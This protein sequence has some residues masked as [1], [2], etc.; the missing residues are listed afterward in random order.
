MRF[1][2]TVILV[3][4]ISI[5]ISCDL[6][7][8]SNSNDFEIK[9]YVNG[10]FPHL[11]MVADH[12]PRT[13]AGVGALMPW[14]DRLW[15]ITYVAHK[16]STGSGTGL[17]SIDE[18][19]NLEKHPKSIV[20]TYANR[21]IHGPSDQLFIGPYTINTKGQV[22]I[23]D[24]LVNHR[25][26]ATMEHLTEPDNKVYVLAMEGEFFEVDVHT[27]EVEKLFDLNIELNMSGGTRPHFKDGFTNHGRVVIANN[28]FDSIN[29]TDGRL[30]EW[31]GNTWKVLKETAFT[32]VWSARAS[33][34]P[35]IATG[36]DKASVILM[37]LIDDEWQTY[38]LPKASRAYDQTSY[39]EWMR[40]REVE[41]ERVLM[42]VHGM[43]YEIG[44]HTWK[45]SL[46]A[47]RPISTHLRI[48]PDFT[49]WRGMLVLGGNQATPMQFGQSNLDR[50][51]LAGQ[52][53][54]GL[55]FGVT[56]DLWSFGKPTGSGG[57]WYDS[58]IEANEY[59]DPFLMGGFDKKSVH[60]YHSSE[61]TVLFTFE[62]D[63]I[64]DGNWHKYKTI[65]VPSD[66][67]VYY[68]FHNSYSAQWIRV[69]ADKN[70]EA[71]VYFIYQ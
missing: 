42:D 23:I 61:S 7:G 63:F 52:P 36:W 22:R 21:I 15:A 62:V 57:V 10:V 71:T 51:P 32:E 66:K 1:L 28:T 43:F 58:E 41:T 18:N 11:G 12:S 55:W 65:E 50:N 29:D 53:Q 19:F 60:L 14:A 17:Y 16:K 38:R 44:Y 64:G 59:S 4:S 70:C 25:L 35:M 39:V 33:G 46:W 5:T 54:A 67:Y 13:E 26:A 34:S 69:K 9:H 68:E 6:I 3:I 27:L 24:G 56:D 47:I 49:S 40:I 37:V 31:D 30:A 20:G 48:I 2:Y 45:G 8:Q